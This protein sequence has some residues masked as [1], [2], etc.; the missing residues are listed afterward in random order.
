MHRSSL[1]K[2]LEDRVDATARRLEAELGTDTACTLH[3][4]GRV[5]GGAK[6]LEG[7]L[8]AYRD[9][10]TALAEAADEPVAG[11]FA[12][13]K[14]RWQAELDRHAGRGPTQWAAYATGG[15]DAVTEACC[16]ADAPCGT[17]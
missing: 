3:R 13:H 10:V 7:R 6:H 12:E 15:L 17:Q 5:T 2:A 4:D 8:I 1:L 11:V 16:L 14:A 9:L